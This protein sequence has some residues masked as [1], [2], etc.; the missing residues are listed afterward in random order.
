MRWLNREERV[1]FVIVTHDLELA[2]RADRMIGLK[3]GQVVSDAA[4]EHAA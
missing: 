2:G 3:D 1:T 4:V